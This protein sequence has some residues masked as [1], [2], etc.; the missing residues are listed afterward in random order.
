MDGGVIVEA[1]APPRSSITDPSEP[2]E[3]FPGSVRSLR[4]GRG[5]CV[6]VPLFVVPA[7]AAE[8]ASSGEGN[9][10]Q[11]A[12]VPQVLIARQQQDALGLSAVT[13]PGSCVT[14]DDGALVVAGGMRI[15]SR[16]GRVEVVGRF[17]EQ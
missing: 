9:E 8:A 2:R 12:V 14:R 15:S 11:V 5:W 4:R 7:V 16:R 10:I 17:V 6:P 1:G 13:A 3:F